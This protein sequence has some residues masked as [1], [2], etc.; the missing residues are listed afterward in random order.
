MLG[1]ANCMMFGVGGGNDVL[2]HGTSIVIFIALL[3]RYRAKLMNQK[4]AWKPSSVTNHHSDDWTILSSF[5]VH[6]L[7]IKLTPELSVGLP[8]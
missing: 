2:A 7:Y 8:S 5:D 3:P 6:L 1:V 4:Q